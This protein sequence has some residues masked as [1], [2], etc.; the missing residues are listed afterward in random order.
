MKS[1]GMRWIVLL[2]ILMGSTQ[3]SVFAQSILSVEEAEKAFAQM[4]KEL[5][6]RTAFL[7]N[8]DS[9]A[10]VFENGEVLNALEKWTKTPEFSAKL[11]WRPVFFAASNAGDL[12]FTTGPYE[13]RKSL[14]DTALSAGQYT[15]IWKKTEK[16]KWKFVLDIGTA[17]PPSD[18]DNQRRE[19]SFTLPPTVPNDLSIAE[20][21]KNFTNLF[22]R[23]PLEAYRNNIFENCWFNLNGYKPATNATVAMNILSKSYL[24]G[25]FIYVGGNISA[26]RDMAFAYGSFLAKDGKKNYLR[27]WTYTALGWKI[28]LQ[29]IT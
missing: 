14:A 19:T 4:A 16:G 18:F 9:N 17:Y 6:V 8:M 24:E 10:V 12:G 2:L 7:A 5:T 28:L 27:I 29:V 13:F 26:S 25:Q 1:N 3:P 21:E 22:E 23:A 15:T 20:L 11:L